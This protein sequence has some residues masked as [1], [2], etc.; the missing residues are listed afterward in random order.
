MKV[1]KVYAVADVVPDSRA[2]FTAGKEYELVSEDEKGGV[3]ITDSGYEVDFCWRT[4]AHLNNG[5]WRRVEREV[6]VPDAGAPV[7][8]VADATSAYDALKAE[9]D[10]LLMRCETAELDLSCYKAERDDARCERDCCIKQMARWQESDKRDF[11][12][13]YVLAYGDNDNAV[14]YAADLYDAI[15]KKCEVTNG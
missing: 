10:E 12:C 5:N 14:D 9:Y 15:V 11:V 1:K 13:R 6:E 3:I 8:P 2:S 7:A 4:S